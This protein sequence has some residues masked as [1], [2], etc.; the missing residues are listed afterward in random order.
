VENYSTFT[1]RGLERAKRATACTFGS[2]SYSSLADILLGVAAR[3]CAPLIVPK[4]GADKFRLTVDLRPINAQTRKNVWP[5]P[6]PEPMLAKLTGSN[7]FFKLDFLHGYWQ[8]PLSKESQ[9]CQSFHTPFGVF[10]PTRVLHGATNAVSYF[11]SSMEN[12]FSNIDLLIWL[13]D[14]LGYAPNEERWIHILRETF[15]DVE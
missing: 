10:T 2:L 5:M 11:Q 9:E 4:S 7:L 8:F 3:Q 6:L 1:V 15:K 14:M 12:L 13:D